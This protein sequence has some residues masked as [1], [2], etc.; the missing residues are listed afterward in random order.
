MAMQSS[1]A[2]PPLNPLIFGLLDRG[3]ATIQLT[4]LRRQADG[5]C[6]DDPKRGV[7]SLISVINDMMDNQHLLTRAKLLAAEGRAVGGAADSDDVAQLLLVMRHECI[8]RLARVMPDAR[9]DDDL[10]HR[11]VLQKV[12]DNVTSACSSAK[13]V[14]DK[15]IAHSATPSSRTSA[16]VTFDRTSAK[17]LWESL[18]MVC[19]V[20][21][22]LLIDLLGDSCGSFLATPLFDHLAGIEALGI[23]D[24]QVA[25]LRRRWDAFDVQCARWSDSHECGRALV[26]PQ[27][28]RLPPRE[29]TTQ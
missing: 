8:D 28:K 2:S 22:F 16:G 9:S 20:T 21:A 12:H 27:A 14:V 29:P 15:F 1:S 19:K 6:I 5:Y 24:D 4:G 26:D 17:K 13:N 11:D 10:V 7:Y 23:N 18:E 25:S 3:F